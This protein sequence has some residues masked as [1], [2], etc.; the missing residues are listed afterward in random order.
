[1]RLRDQLLEAAE[2]LA[3][4]AHGLQT[5]LAATLVKQAQHRTLA[6]RAGQC[7]DPHVDRT[8]ADAQADPSVLRQALLRNIELGHYLQPRYQRRVQRTVGL[9]HFAQ[10]PVDPEAH[11]AVAFVG[12]DVDIAG[13]V[14]R[15]LG[16]QRVEQANDRR[17]I[18]GLQQ[19]LDRRQLLHHAPEVGVGFNLTGY[20]RGARLPLRV[21]GADALHQL[22]GGHR[23]HGM[24][25]VLAQ[26]LAHRAARGGGVQHQ[27]LPG[28]VVLQQQL[29]L[30]GKGVGKR[31]L[32]RDRVLWTAAAWAIS[33]LAPLA[34]NTMAQRATQ[35]PAAPA[36]RK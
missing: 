6:V 18:G 19:V 31:K 30:P 23:L 35:Q 34:G 17:I 4:H 3:L 29:V 24:H 1:M 16:Q 22:F 7:A 25:R 20:P 13:T 2:R 33:A 5:E 15:G 12:F 11:A 21:G 27:R 26:H 32:H 36:D 28:A 9:H 14:P 8:G 10:R